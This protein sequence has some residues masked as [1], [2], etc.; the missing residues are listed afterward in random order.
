MG[1]KE[2][3]EKAKAAEDQAKEAAAAYNQAKAEAG[4]D[5]QP[6]K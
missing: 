2:L 5:V 3:Q 1:V 6:L 4:Q